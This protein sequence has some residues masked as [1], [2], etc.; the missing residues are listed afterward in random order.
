MLAAYQLWTGHLYG[1]GLLLDAAAYATNW[2]AGENIP[3]LDRALMGLSFTGGCVLTALT[4]APLLWHVRGWIVAATVALSSG[5]LVATRAS[6]IADGDRLAVGAHAVF[7]VAGGLSLLALAI[8]DVRRERDPDSSLLAAW[9]IG[10]F[11]FAS[12]VNW[13]INGRSILPL[14]P[15]AGILIVR[16]LGRMPRWAVPAALAVSAIVSLVVLVGDYQ[17][18]GTAREA[19]RVIHAKSQ[20]RTLQFE[21]HWGFQYYMESWGAKPLDMVKVDLNPGEVVAI[22]YNNTQIVG[23]PKSKTGSTDRFE[24]GPT[25]PAATMRSLAGAG[26]YASVFGPLPYRLGAMA[27]ERYSMIEVK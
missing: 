24:I 6:G 10:T 23:L 27:P 12:F 9:V 14:V 7:F 21:G 25:L 8:N 19:S 20:G 2:R 17:L 1:R 22:A 16:K 26:F 18:A 15:A 3:L 4:F 5:W 13:T 11:V